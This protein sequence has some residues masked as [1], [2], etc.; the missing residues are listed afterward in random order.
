MS[1]EK[2]NKLEFN[3]YCIFTEEELDIKEVIGQIFK[4]YL[5]FKTKV[6]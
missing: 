4:D 5:Q 6:K 2:D 1:K 3:V